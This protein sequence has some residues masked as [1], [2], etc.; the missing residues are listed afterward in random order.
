[1]ACDDR[2]AVDQIVCA[3]TSLEPEWWEPWLPLVAIALSVAAPFAVAW[4]VAKKSREQTFE[5]IQAQIE[6]N[7]AAVEAQITANQEAIDRQIQAGAEQ[8]IRAVEHQVAADRQQREREVMRAKVEQWVT[9]SQQEHHRRLDEAISAGTGA[10][11]VVIDALDLAL[12]K[13][14]RDAMEPWFSNSGLRLVNIR[15]IQRTSSDLGSDVM[16]SWWSTNKTLAQALVDNEDN[17]DLL[18]AAAKAF[19]DELDEEIRVARA[20]LEG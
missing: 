19:A 5:A 17:P 12:P 15:T 20:K 8:T 4:W 18:R 14:L 7:R 10:Y 1:M 6:A 3:I 9:A 2:E 13:A 11:T 16:T